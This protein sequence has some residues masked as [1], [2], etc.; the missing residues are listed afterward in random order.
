MKSITDAPGL[1]E[2]S[3]PIL[4]RLLTV[5]ESGWL[6]GILVCDKEISCSGQAEDLS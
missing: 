1:S 2:I 4:S 5:D 3:V 6:D